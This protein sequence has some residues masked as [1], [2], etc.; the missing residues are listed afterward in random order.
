MTFKTRFNRIILKN[1]KLSYSKN[2]NRVIFSKHKH[3]T[4]L[5]RRKATSHKKIALKKVIFNTQNPDFLFHVNYFM[6]LSNIFVDPVN[7]KYFCEIVFP[8]K[9]KIIIPYISGLK[10]GEVY[11]INSVFFRKHQRRIHKVHKE[12]VICN[13]VSGSKRFA[14]S[15]GSYAIKLNNGSIV[16][17]SG[18]K[19]KLPLDSFYYG[20][21]FF[22][23]DSRKMKESSCIVRGIAKNPVDHP[24]GGN[25]NI[26]KPFKTP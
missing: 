23:K 14:Q 10:F 26:K 5:L 25:S 13:V 15:I 9:I 12:G 6:A 21:N 18:Q 24:N 2:F 3:H 16:L 17:P 1:N 19:S 22:F 7:A 20:R 4:G 11:D 8:Y